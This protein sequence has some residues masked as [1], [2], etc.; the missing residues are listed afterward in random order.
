[1]KVMGCLSGITLNSATSDRFFL[2][3]PELARLS[4]EM[5]GCEPK[6]QEHHHELTK[7]IQKRHEENINSLKATFQF[8]RNPLSYDGDDLIIVIDGIVMPKQIQEDICIR[9]D[10]GQ[11]EYERF[12]AERVQ[13]DKVNIWNH[14]KKIKLKR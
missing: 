4:E 7:A 9:G 1:M 2:T 13:S 5:A 14:V 10:V 6:E 12:V 11:Q 3:A 8:T